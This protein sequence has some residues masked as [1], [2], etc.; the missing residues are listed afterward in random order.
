MPGKSVDRGFT[1]VELLVVIAIIGILVALLLPAVQSAREA[2]RRVD[3]TNRVKQIGLAMLAHLTTHK[4]LPPGV[5]TCTPMSVPEHI[6]GGV[7][8]G[9]VCE[10]PV[11]TVNILPFLEEASLG[12]FSRN[13]M[14]PKFSDAG[15][16]ADDAP[17]TTPVG[18]T[19]GDTTPAEYICPS[20]DQMLKRVSSWDLEHLSKGNYVANFGAD[21][22]MSYQKPNKAGLFG[23]ERVAAP[24]PVTAQAEHPSTDGTWKIAPNQGLR[25]RKV[26]DGMSK[27]MMVSE[28]NGFDDP[29]DGRGAWVAAPMGCTSYTAKFGP[30]SNGTDKVPMCLQ[31][32]PGFPGFG[33]PETDPRR[34]S[35]GR[36]GNVW[37]SARSKHNGGVNVVMGDGATRFV[38]DDIDLTIWQAMSTRAGREVQ[39]E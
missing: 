4:T 38:V 23:V 31:G 20:A 36:D 13:A 21:T 16:F 8:T 28:I 5:P 30:N 18:Q 11:W 17:N 3:C 12:R 10:G 39:T 27:T 25:V 35:Q 34:C 22:F 7:Q 33:I 26:V 24:G 29:A 9:N 14:D 19:V 2:A 32:F 15:H 37:S 6:R 1:L